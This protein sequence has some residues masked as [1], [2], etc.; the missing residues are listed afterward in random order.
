[1]DIESESTCWLDPL[2]QV[3]VSI[4]STFLLAGQIF[5]AVGSLLLLI[6]FVYSIGSRTKAG[7]RDTLWQEQRMQKDAPTLS[8]KEKT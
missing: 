5:Q 4:I 3:M 1:M 7:P 2:S 6:P 8:S